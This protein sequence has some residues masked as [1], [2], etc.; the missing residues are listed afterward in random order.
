MP[1][2]DCVILID[3]AYHFQTRSTFLDLVSRVCM[4]S[5]SRIALADILLTD[6]FH[7]ASWW[8]RTLF[9]RVLM[10]LMR[11]PRAN[12]KTQAEYFADL[13]QVGFIG[14]QFDIIT[15]HVFLPLSHNIQTRSQI[16]RDKRWIPFLIFSH[17][18]RFWIDAKLLDFV[19]VT[20]RL[21]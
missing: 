1:C 21:A 7:K 8:R 15:E 9:L 5:G 20:A 2:F 11:V 16:Y 14:I 3:C 17:L 6:D 13:Q 19:V 10:P 18:M 4:D 12:L